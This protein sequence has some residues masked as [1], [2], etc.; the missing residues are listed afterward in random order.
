MTEQPHLG[1][2]AVTP[3][4]GHGK[5][6]QPEVLAG[7]TGNRDWEK[8]QGRPAGGIQ[9]F[10]SP[11]VELFIP[12]STRPVFSNGVVRRLQGDDQLWGRR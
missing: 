12:K 1:G 2:K 9:E 11:N 3:V 8:R 10:R 4:I 7:A 6:E 5:A